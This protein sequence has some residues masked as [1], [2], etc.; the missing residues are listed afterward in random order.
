VGKIPGEEVAQQYADQLRSKEGFTPFVIR[1]DEA[2]P[3]GVK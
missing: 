3:S 2:A 1:L